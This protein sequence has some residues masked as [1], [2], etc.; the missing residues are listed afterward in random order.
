MLAIRCHPTSATAT[1]SDAANPAARP[2]V[3]ALRP[4]FRRAGNQP[5]GGFLVFAGTGFTGLIEA[6]L[7]CAG[8]GPVG[9]ACAGLMLD[10]HA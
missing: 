7:K 9:P 2:H 8:A 6:G 10:G 3:E 4:V 5:Y 1:T